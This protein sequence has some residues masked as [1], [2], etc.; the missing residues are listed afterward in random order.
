[1][2]TAFIETNRLPA[3]FSALAEQFY[4]PLASQLFNLSKQT[5]E[6]FFV[7]ING[8]QGSGKSTLAAFI[9]DYLSHNHQLNV[10]V[11]SL[12]DFYLSQN[13]RNQ[14][15]SQVHPLFKTRGVPGTHNT[16]LLTTVLQRLKS[17]HSGFLIPR[18]NKASDE[19]FA[20]SE[21]QQVNRPADLVIVEGWCWG[22][23]PQTSTQ[24]VVP[25]NPL[26]QQQD[27]EGIWRSH[28]NKQLVDDYLP[29]YQLFDYWVALQAPSF[30]FVHHWRL[31]QEQKLAQTLPH[32][33]QN[34]LMSA[35][36]IGDFIQYFQRLTEH[37]L[38]TLGD[39]ADTTFCLGQ[40]REISAVLKKDEK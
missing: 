15:A 29:L 37:S 25:V 8:C 18:F 5:S 31:E 11:M 1:M 26:E 21:W 34:K 35:A 33:E 17:G 22:V 23:Q 16:Q 6:P 7:G 4:Q 12:D 19:P 20:T 39:I 9:A 14:L 27:A 38:N 32:G 3:T 36:Q 24:L 30:E 2:M 40:H 28:V 10:V 13:K